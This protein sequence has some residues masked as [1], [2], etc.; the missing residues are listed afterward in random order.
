MFRWHKEIERLD[1]PASQ[2]LHLERSLSV[3]QVALPG[4][5][6]QEAT[7]Y[8]CAFA[9]GKGLRVGLVL[10]LHTSQYLAFYLHERA[11]APL[12]E[13]G[14]LIE[15][16]A[17]FAESLGFMLSDMDYRKLGI[18]KR[19]ALWESLPLKAGVEAPTPVAAAAFVAVEEPPVAVIAPAPAKLASVEPPVP[20]PSP[21][22]PADE[23]ILEL[24]DEAPFTPPSAE[25][26]IVELAE[27]TPFTPPAEAMPDALSGSGPTMRARARKRLP[28][29]KEMTARR[30][31]L[32]ESLGRFLA[33]L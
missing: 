30:Q 32:L 17:H 5:P 22:S 10:H 23:A 14:R 19:D 7:A 13:V 1:I 8:L 26:V 28:S 27:E 25:E 33:S 2:V 15:E 9:V 16:G 29:A 24:A 4:L 20:A 21:P 31:K 12:Q 18:K 11:E 3:A 6:S